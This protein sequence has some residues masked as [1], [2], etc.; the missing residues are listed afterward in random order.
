MEEGFRG[1]CSRAEGH[2]E[3]GGR[4]FFLENHKAADRLPRSVGVNQKSAREHHPG[5]APA[6]Q[7]PQPNGGALGAVKCVFGKC[8]VIR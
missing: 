1:S 6:C 2:G 3:A 5:H 7:P 8:N 4:Y